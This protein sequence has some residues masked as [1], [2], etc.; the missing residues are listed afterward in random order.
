MKKIVKLLLTLGLTL[1]LTNLACASMVGDEVYVKYQD[2]FILESQTVIVQGGAQDAVD[3]LL[4]DI[5]VNLEADSIIVDFNNPTSFA[6]AFFAGLIIDDLNDSNLYYTLLDVNVVT[7]LTGWSDD[8]I[9]FYDDIVMFNWAG[10]FAD[11]DTNFIADLVFGQNPVPIPGT[12]LLFMTGI[13]GFA[14]LRKNKTVKNLTK[15]C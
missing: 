15:E 4:G 9:L 3:F 10:L 8:R 12:L 14:L 2:P 7:D 11:S 6:N 5:T 1:G 13:F